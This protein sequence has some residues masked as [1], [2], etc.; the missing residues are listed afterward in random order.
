[1]KPRSILSSVDAELPNLLGIT[2][3]SDHA[4]GIFYMLT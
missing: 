4:G 2:T 1:M 3:A